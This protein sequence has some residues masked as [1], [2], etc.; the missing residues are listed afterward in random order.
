MTLDDATALTIGDEGVW[1]RQKGKLFEI[2][3]T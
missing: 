3:P 1:L 2:L